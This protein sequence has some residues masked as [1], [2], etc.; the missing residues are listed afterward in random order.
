MVAATAVAGF[1]A[2]PGPNSKAFLQELWDTPVPSGEQRY[3]DGMLYLM[4]LMHIAGEYRIIEP[5]PG[6]VAR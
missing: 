4:S 2:T 1:A 3:F 5:Q 6:K